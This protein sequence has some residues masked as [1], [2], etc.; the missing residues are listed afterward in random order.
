MNDIIGLDLD[1]SREYL[2]AAL[3]ASFFSVCVLV[4]IFFYLNRYTK[5]RYFSYWTVAWM[6]H[7]FWLALCIALQNVQENPELIMLKQWCVG[8]SAV[9]LLSGSAWFLNQRIRPAQL[10]LFLAFLFFWSF[11]SVYQFDSL[12]QM[13]LPVFALVGVASWATAWCFFRF[14]KD[15]PY[16]GA[17]LVAWG[18]GLWGCYISAY[19]FFQQ[20]DQMI[21]SGYFISAIL[22]LF[23]AVS[24]IIL[25]LEEVRHTNQLAF[26]K[27]RSFKSKTDFLKNKVLSTEERYR[28]LFDQASE[29]IVITDAEDL[30]VLELNQTAKRL[31]GVGSGDTTVSLSS[32]CQLHPAP[33]PMP[34]T[35]PEWFGAICRHRHLNL[36]RRDGAVTPVETDG[37]PI[38]FDGKAAY[39]F[40]LRELTERARLEQQLRQAEKLSALGQ[41]ISGVAHEL[42]N[43]LA[44]IKGYLE[45]IL[46]RDQLGQSTRADLEKV[47]HESN[48]AAKLVNNFLSFARE[49]PVHREPLDLNEVV[50]RSAELRKLDL[51]KAGVEVKLDLDPNLPLTQADPDQ[52]QQ[53]LVNLLSNAL[54]ALAE[55]PKEGRL[56]ITTRK[57]ANFIQLLVEDNGPGVPSDVLPY[58]FEPF[59]TTKEVGRGT[60][61]GLSIAHSIMT[62]HHGRIACQPSALGGAGFLVELPIVSAGVPAPASPPDATAPARAETPRARSAHIL[63][64]D[65]EQ[66][67]AELLGEMLGL[68]GY[69]TTLCH[70]APDALQLLAQRDFDLIISDFRM[71][72]MNGQE[73]Y[74]QAIQMK[75]ELARNIL[76]LTGDVVSEETQTF[77]QSTGNPHLSKPFQLAQ[78]EQLVVQILQSRSKNS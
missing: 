1:F 23:I 74:Q 66:S 63:V 45:L 35:G 31:L 19:P 38:N 8:A 59:F 67:I 54:H 33:K 11:L 56:R 75:P 21:S 61:L 24:M 58:I 65:D 57:E 36:V 14:R 76:F 7:A 47:A 9:F 43:P 44:V 13:Q 77:L 40:F 72:K 73:F 70:S 22:Q 71:P 20:S 15:Q 69:S 32:F 55:S 42:N 17:G 53:V 78:V 28:S 41:M 49:Q 48:R 64:L 50:R 2:K 16:L 52:I 46:R 37:A 6:F 51:L 34:Q 29:G 10:A 27:I 62:D 25:V 68:L 26:Q 3:V 5:R 4:G 18:F 30:R 12:L 39:Q 60:G